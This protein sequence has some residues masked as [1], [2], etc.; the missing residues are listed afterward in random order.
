MFLL[1]QF[2]IL[3][4]FVFLALGSLED[5]R[6][7]EIPERISYG[8]VA[9]AL[10][11]AALDSAFSG[12]AYFFLYSLLAGA[13]FFAVGY[14]LFYFGQW[15]GG[16]VKLA[17][18][19]GCTLGYLSHAGFFF[20][21][22]FPYYATYFINLVCI[23]L[24]YATVYGLLLGLKS[25]ETWKEF[26]RYLRDKRTAIV[27]LLSFAPSLIA[28]YMGLYNL[29]LFYTVIPLMALIAFYLKAVELKAL[30]E[31]VD[32]SKLRVGDVP[33]EDLEAGGEVFVRKRDIEGM[34]IEDV[35][36][37]QKLASQ[38]KMPRQIIIKRGIKFAPV[39]LFALASV[40]YI[41]NFIEIVIRVLT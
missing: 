12:D 10:T 32:V 9:C 18:G 40:L 7:G 30:R 21:G 22:L 28:Q 3:L 34:S 33:A 15:G 16:D 26:S 14:V 13:G 41:G 1:V 31:T 27:F 23:A 8:Y 35:E 36:K 6:T 11:V 5:L 25:P 20:D 38:G 39:L 4:A 19:I 29:A 2:A 24:P 17:A 37:I